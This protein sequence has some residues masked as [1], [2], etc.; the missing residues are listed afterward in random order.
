M[1]KCGLSHQEPKDQQA[2]FC[3][4]VTKTA[5]LKVTWHPRNC[6]FWSNSPSG[7]SAS[8]AKRSK[9]WHSPAPDGDG[10]KSE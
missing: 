10:D 9:R 5:G 3:D 6:R 1:G 2:Q 4:D 8:E 7:H